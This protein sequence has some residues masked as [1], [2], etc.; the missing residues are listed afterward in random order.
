MTLRICKSLLMAGVALFYTLVVLNNTTD[1]DSNYQFVRH[2]LMMDSTFAGNRAMWRAVNSSTIHGPPNWP[3]G[4]EILC[5][6][7][8]VILAS[9]GRASKLGDGTCAAART[10]PPRSTWRRRGGMVTAGTAGTWSSALRAAAR[11]FVHA[12]PRRSAR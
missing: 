11:H 1:Y 5:I 12:R 2:V 10:T 7:S 6:T 4:S 9:A 8:K 3:G